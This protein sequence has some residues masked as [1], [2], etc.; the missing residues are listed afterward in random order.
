MRLALSVGYW[1][2]GISEQDQLR[3]VKDAEAAVAQAESE[4]KARKYA[5][6]RELVG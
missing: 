5:E 3:M 6:D 1:G 2:L 4:E